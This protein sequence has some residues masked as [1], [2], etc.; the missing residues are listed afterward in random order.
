M[1][2]RVVWSRKSEHNL[3]AI[4]EFIAKDSEV[5]AAR[6]VKRLVI[7]TEEYVPKNKFSGRLVPEFSDMPLSF[8]REF[9]FHGYRVIYDPREESEI[10]IVA[11]LNGRM[12]IERQFELE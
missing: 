2:Q 4:Y 7:S 12:R 6:F 8:L 3:H 5:Y 11:V 1:A 10:V 9:I